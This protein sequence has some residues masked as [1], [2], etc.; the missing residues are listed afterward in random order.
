MTI[1]FPAGLARLDLRIQWGRLVAR[2]KL[3]GSWESEDADPYWTGSLT[4][5]K[6]TDARLQD[7]EAFAA[8]A[9]A[10][11]SVIAF[12]DP[13]FRLPLAYRASGLPGDWDGTGEVEAL[14]DPSAPV[15]SGLPVGVTLKRGDRLNLVDGTAR[16]YHML[17]ADVTVASDTAQALPIVP[18]ALPNA[19]SAGAGV[20][21][22][23]P[24]VGL[25][26][27]ANSWTAPRVARQLT[28]ATASLEEAATVPPADEEL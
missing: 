12:V 6:L 2:D 18:Y 16:S 28:V 21:F 26:I 20:S 22:A 19:F 25:H 23:D 11:R 13:V 3:G 14:D 7:W 1:S 17:R 27:V 4:T 10:A 24:S 5:S 9:I 15:V 8:G